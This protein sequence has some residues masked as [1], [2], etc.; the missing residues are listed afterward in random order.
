MVVLCRPLLRA[1][2][3]QFNIQHHVRTVLAEF[4][5]GLKSWHALALAD[6]DSRLQ[7]VARPIENVLTLQAVMAQLA[8]V[9]SMKNHRDIVFAKPDLLKNISV[10]IERTN[11]H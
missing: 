8:V 7:L 1:R 5:E 10:N 9:T 6:V 2:C 11:S 4:E 3:F